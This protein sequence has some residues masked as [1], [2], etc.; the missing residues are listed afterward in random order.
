MPVRRRLVRVNGVQIAITPFPERLH[1][2]FHK[3]VGVLFR[4][5]HSLWERHDQ[6]HHLIAVFAMLFE[7]VRS[8]FIVKFRNGKR[9]KTFIANERVPLQSFRFSGNIQQGVFRF[10]GRFNV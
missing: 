1:V 5:I 8:D 9:V 3:P 6:M 4:H 2:S 7:S 10:C